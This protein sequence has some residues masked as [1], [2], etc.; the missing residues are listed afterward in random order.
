MTGGI[1]QLVAR[2]NQDIYLTEDAQ[3]TFF[4]IVYRRHTNFSMETIKQRFNK[5][6]NF[7]EKMSATLARLGDLCGQIYVVIELPSVSNISETEEYYFR[8]VEHIGFSI[9]KSVEIEIGGKLIDKHYGEWLY[10]WHE[11]TETKEGIN[12]MIG[13]IPELTQLSKTK[14]SYKL[15][16]PLQFWFCKNYGVAL[17][18]VN[19][20]F[21]EVRINLELNSASNCYVAS[22]TH[23]ITIHEDIVNFKQGELIKQVLNNGTTAYGEYVYYDKLLKRLYYN[24]LSQKN[25]PFVS[26]SNSNILSDAEKNTILR[27]ENNS[28]Y[29]IYG[30]TTKYEVIPQINSLEKKFKIPSINTLN[31]IDCYLLV[32]YMYLDEEER[33]KFS[34]T[35]HEY[36]IEQIQYSGDKF[37]ESHGSKVNLS[38]ENSTKEIIW[39]VQSVNNKQR[40]E[41]FN[42]TNNPDR[43]IGSSLIINETVQINGNDRIT[44]R[45]AKYFDTIQLYQNHKKAVNTG[46][47]CYSFCLFPS[48]YQPS[49][50]INMSQVTNLS[51]KLNLDNTVTP[52]NPA[53]LRCYAISNNILRVTNGIAGLVFNND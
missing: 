41:Y 1:I 15:Y 8:W 43:Y 48:L 37:V 28:Y 14:N 10:I 39:V 23:Y 6:P 22:P 47:N 51:I 42:Y 9:I 20:Q 50:P 2:G 3:I 46:I 5:E 25:S 34:N 33:E 44:E 35:K 29:R 53:S 18:L 4:K 12:K 38:F 45:E 17:P 16:I 19:L 36:L 27:E 49:G 32:N 26:I 7:D 21:S 24:K 52:T 13:N 40:K 31:I 11:L 30:T